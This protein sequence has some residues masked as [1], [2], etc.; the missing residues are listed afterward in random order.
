M[1][2]DFL[3]IQVLDKIEGLGFEIYKQVD[4]DIKK[5]MKL[6]AIGNAIDFGF[7][8]LE[9]AMSIIT[10]QAKRKLSIDDRN[11]LIKKIKEAESIVIAA[12]NAGECLFDVLLIKAIKKITDA[13]LTYLVNTG[14]ILNDITFKE[15]KKLGF[16]K[17]VE[18]RETHDDKGGVPVRLVEGYDLV[19][20]KG[21]ANYC[22]LSEHELNIG[23]LIN[24]KCR[25]IAQ[26]I[27]VPV[28]STIVY[29]PKSGCLETKS[30]MIGIRS[31]A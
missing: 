24:L 20:S 28:K 13:S 2:G 4:V 19:I 30:R 16:D 25:L 8:D 11:V 21:Q 5:A 22:A 3:N 27:G 12:D 26:D 29:S 10:T 15:A 17:F 9:T 18:V 31:D 1:L 7:Y 23:Y 6:A 14:Q